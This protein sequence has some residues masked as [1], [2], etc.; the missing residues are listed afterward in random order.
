MLRQVYK[1]SADK[2]G[3]G[4]CLLYLTV[5]K[6]RGFSRVYKGPWWNMSPLEAGQAAQLRDYTL[7]RFRILNTGGTPWSQRLT[8]SSLGCP[9]LEE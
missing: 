7:H 2:S 1:T 6:A 5:Y 4:N 8:V 3:G 9:G